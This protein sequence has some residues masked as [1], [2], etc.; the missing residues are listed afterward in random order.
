VKGTKLAEEVDVALREL[1]RRLDS[2][3][4]TPRAIAALADELRDDWA[5]RL[6]RLGSWARGT[7]TQGEAA[8]LE[9]LGDEF[10]AAS[11]R[12][13]SSL[14]HLSRL[15]L[16]RLDLARRALQPLLE[17]TEAEL[18]A[19]G[20]ETYDDLLAHARAL[21]ADHPHVRERVRA[22]IDQLLVDE[23]QDTD[24]VQCEIIGWLALDGA[25]DSRPGLFLVGDPKQSIY[26]WRGAD[27]GAYESFVERVFDA[28]G[29][30]L[31]LSVNFRSVPSI[32]TEVER[33]IEPVM[34]Q[35]HG[36]Q[37]AFAPLFARD[38][39]RGSPGFVRGD[40]RS[41][42][43]W[44]SW[45]RASAGS[46][47]A[48]DNAAETAEL[49]ARALAR[50]IRSLHDEHG[51]PWR[52]VG[53]LFR[54]RGDLDTYV[55]A[56]RDQQ[57]PHVVSGDRSYNRRREII[58][59]A[60]LVRCVLDPNDH[61][62][63]LTWLRSPSGGVPDAA[64]LPL[65]A[66]G[67]PAQMSNL[68]GPEPEPLRAIERDLG[69]VAAA[70]PTDEVPGLDRIAGWETCAFAAVKAVAAARASFERDPADLFVEKLRRES[71][72]EL[73]EAARYQGVYRVANLDRFFRR[74][75]D[76]LESSARDPNAVLREL[77]SQVDR[78]EEA[79]E[80]R[81]LESADDA[82]QILTIH[83]AK[84]LTFTHVYLMQLHK[85]SRGRANRSQFSGR[86]DG[87]LEY[88]LLGAPTPGFGSL[89]AQRERSE[90]AERVRT[91]YVAMTRPRERLVLA[92]KWPQAG[93]QKALGAAA[94]H[95]DLLGQRSV[96][97][98]DL[99]ALAAKEGNPGTDVSGAH[100]RFPALDDPGAAPREWPDDD[101]LPPLDRVAD[102]ARAIL[103][104]REAARVRMQRPTS[105]PASE[106]PE[107]RR[108]Q[109]D[110]D[111]LLR[112][113]AARE[114]GSDPRIARVVGTAIHRLLEELDLDAEPGAELARLRRQIPAWL[115]ASLDGEDR[116]RASART[117]QIL[118]RLAEGPLLARLH[119]LRDRVVARELATLSPPELGDDGPV[120][121]VA[122]AVDL[123]YRDPASDALVVADFKTD[124]IADERSLSERAHSYASQGAVYTRAIQQALGLA[125]R[126]RFELW[127]LD[128][129]RIEVVDT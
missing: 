48:P 122:G 114:E 28:G 79:E 71:L 45:P 17:R 37:P 29:E 47:P 25:Q 115:Q 10:R 30:E 33:V 116:A 46:P 100:W 119:A 53:V 26:A 6:G 70:L 125:E 44:I 60:A 126:P 112:P 121:F 88:R 78:G 113:S 62:S 111:E 98:P 118:D 83:Q 20:A 87:R 50:D 89:E 63:L 23:F 56:L 12:V 13:R 49:E 21:L 84:G 7:F 77:R 24:V 9:S 109:P 108:E 32:L 2:A 18:R 36:V 128:V 54:S 55:G 27:L 16:P 99:D 93:K 67:F 107:R 52:E 59:A 117:E 90:A 1:R 65:W 39:L 82:V 76:Q 91:L 127:F 123:L 102:D 66:R 5:R 14:L 106:D 124:R 96:E 80:A 110:D 92:G 19:R 120:G 103:R 41:V 11:A 68:A 72:I 38:D 64:L 129:G 3:E 73:S 105:R 75:I 74:L 51:V 101:E 43:Y 22:G 57:V 85:G 81:P 61:L 8:R 35:E 104:R 31:R 40:R 34:Q 97:P 4:C 86:V 69:E 58:D 95:V 94:C 15:D 42:E